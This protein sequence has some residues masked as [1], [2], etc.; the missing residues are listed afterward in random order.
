MSSHHRCCDRAVVAVLGLRVDERRVTVACPLL[1]LASVLRL[2]IF[3][4]F[5]RRGTGLSVLNMASKNAR[6]RTS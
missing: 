6:P 4:V 3:F 2:N 1:L 5:L